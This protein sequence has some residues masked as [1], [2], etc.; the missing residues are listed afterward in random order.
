MDE[1]YRILRA[2][3]CLRGSAGLRCTLTILDTA[4]KIRARM[5][6]DWIDTFFVLRGVERGIHHQV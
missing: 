6:P 1:Q 2:D 5:T 3:F 4:I